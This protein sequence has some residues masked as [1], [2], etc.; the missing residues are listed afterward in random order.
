MEPGQTVAAGQTLF[1]IVDPDRLEL[2]AQLPTEQQAALHVGNQ[3]E[4][5]IQGNP[6][7]FTARLSRVAPIADLSSR[8]IEF[9]AT[10]QQNIPSLSIGAFIEGDIISGQAIAGQLIPLDVIQ[11]LDTKPYVWVI[12]QQ[13]VAKVALEVL[14]QNYAL[15]QAVVNG[16]SA[17]DQISR[18]NFTDQQINHAVSITQ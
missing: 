13:K 8:Q 18:V 14:E 6:S 10:P 7:L 9:F 2:Q 11:N 5:R 3:I 16:L 12:R 15:N 1:E 17:N 4:Y